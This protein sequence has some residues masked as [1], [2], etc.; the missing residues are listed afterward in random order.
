MNRST[1][2]G[3]HDQRFF[4]LEKRLPTLIPVYLASIEDRHTRERTLT[5]NISPHGARVISMRS[6]RQGEETLI[7]PSTGEFPRVGRVIY[8]L[9]TAGDRFCLG[10]EFPDRAVKWGDYS[11]A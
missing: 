2:R 5:E 9:P 4:R 6:W 11:S 7:T 8:C 1:K 10:L 3:R